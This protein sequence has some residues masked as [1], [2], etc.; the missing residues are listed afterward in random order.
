MVDD[1]AFGTGNAEW[2]QSRFN[3]MARAM[4]KVERRAQKIARG[5][6]L[7]LSPLVSAAVRLG[8]SSRALTN[9][10]I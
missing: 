4:H 8:V 5:L 2:D 10:V 1:P 9:R 6:S 3:R 7:S